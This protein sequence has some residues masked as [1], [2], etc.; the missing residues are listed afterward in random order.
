[1]VR[2]LIKNSANQN[3]N[4]NSQ[5]FIFYCDRNKNRLFGITIIKNYVRYRV[6]QKKKES[7]LNE[8]I[9]KSATCV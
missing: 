4:A 1:M 5:N 8:S 7:L 3:K 6:G 2:I 9:R